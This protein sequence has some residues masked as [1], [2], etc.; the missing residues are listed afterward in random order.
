MDIENHLHT[1]RCLNLHRL[2]GENL[3]E[4]ELNQLHWINKEIGVLKKQKEELESRSYVKGQEITDMPFGTGTTDKVGSRAIAM[5]E[6]NEL[7]EI[8]LKELYVVRG[9]IERYINTVDDVEVRL[10]LRLRCINNLSWEQIAN[11]TGYER[12]TVSKKYHNHFNKYKF[13]TNPVSK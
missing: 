3:T 10:I 9:R 7:Y 12:T 8:K 1:G 6:I 5:Q 11:E 13:P 2:R 4:K